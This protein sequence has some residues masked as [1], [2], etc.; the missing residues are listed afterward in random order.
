MSL[1]TLKPVACRIPPVTGANGSH[2]K[3]TMVNRQAPPHLQVKEKEEPLLQESL[4]I[5]TSRREMMHLTAASLGL[6][7]L[8]L[9]AT[10]EAR[11]R[12][13]TMRQKIMEKLEEL[14]QKAGLSKPKDEGEEKKP[15]EEPKD[16]IEDKKP[17]PNG[18][19]AEEKKPKL[20][21]NGD[22]TKA[23]TTEQQPKAAAPN[24]ELSIPALP[25]ILN[26]V[27]V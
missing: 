19:K 8:L 17:K 6:V 24:G 9:P 25:N 3:V 4:T 11:P 2:S 15:K 1:W 7:S 26:D 16:K 10:A 22:E 21:D 27:T 13:A 5:T 12:N 14:R 20:K 23:A 18:S